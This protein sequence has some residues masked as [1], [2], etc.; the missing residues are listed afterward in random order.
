[1]IARDVLY[2]EVIYGPRD[3]TRQDS[4]I[5]MLCE[6]SCRMLDMRVI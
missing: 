2:D 4:P 5:G 1:M 3:K 6:I